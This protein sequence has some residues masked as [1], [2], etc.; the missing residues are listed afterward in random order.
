MR[1]TSRRRSGK[2]A[3][4]SVGYRNSGERR[5]RCA[6]PFT[7]TCRL[8]LLTMMRVFL[9]GLLRYLSGVALA[10]IV[11]FAVSNFIKISNFKHLWH[12]SRLDFRVAPI[13]YGGVLFFRHF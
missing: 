4:F 1:L 3:P 10:A 12:T 11:L 6:N 9:S 8:G 2:G 7:A 5:G 13:T